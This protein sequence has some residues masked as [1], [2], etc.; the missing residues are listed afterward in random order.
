MD[1]MSQLAAQLQG[2]PLFRDLRPALLAELSPRCRKRRFPP[3]ETIVREGDPGRTLFVVLRGRVG[4]FKLNERGERIH[5]KDL[6]AGD[7]FG[8]MAL[9]DGGPRSSDV[10]TIDPT[11]LLMLDQDEFVRCLQISPATALEILRTLC[12]RLRQ[13]DERLGSSRPVRERLALV[14]LEL[15][16]SASPDG[17]REK[18]P[19][20][21]DVSRQALAD[22]CRARRETGSRE[23]AN[24][25]EA[26]A[27]RLLG[28]RILVLPQ[29]L[30]SLCDGPV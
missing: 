15:C 16:A 4:I 9:L 6:V 17:A 26:G 5:L 3:G 30:R 20:P 11:E 21:L 7:H 19:V 8:E 1:G 24:L 10:V 23:L 13:A 12:L 28:R 2:V 27:V 14:L 18:G 25:Q 29:R 22:R